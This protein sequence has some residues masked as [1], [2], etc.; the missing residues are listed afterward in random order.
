MNLISIGVGHSLSQ[1]ATGLLHLLLRRLAVFWAA[2]RIR[3]LR[4]LPLLQLFWILETR[5]KTNLGLLLLLARVGHLCNEKLRKFVKNQEKR[6]LGSDRKI[7]GWDYTVWQLGNKPS[8]QI[9]S[10]SLRLL[11]EISAAMSNSYFCGFL[12]YYYILLSAIICSRALEQLFGGTSAKMAVKIARNRPENE[13]KEGVTSRF[14]ILK[15]SWRLNEN[16]W[17][18]YPKTRK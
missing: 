17:L 13:E 16:F 9:S 14:W 8:S 7:S 15:S 11:Q 3:A 12:D 6:H 2:I 10:I 18:P 4:L 1:R 5:I